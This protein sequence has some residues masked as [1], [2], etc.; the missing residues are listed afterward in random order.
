LS[1]NATYIIISICIF[2]SSACLSFNLPALANEAPVSVIA[3]YPG[4]IFAEPEKI[5][6]GN[7]SLIG[8]LMMFTIPQLFSQKS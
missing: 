5:Q 1:K 7:S 4:R 6:R 8:I 2:A 3:Q